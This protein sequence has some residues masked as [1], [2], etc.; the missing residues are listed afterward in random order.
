M[1]TPSYSR[2]KKTKDGK[3]LTQH[4]YSKRGIEQVSLLEE[5]LEEGS[6]QEA[7]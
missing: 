6:G 1:V 3:Q 2:E 5:V 7:K 4:K